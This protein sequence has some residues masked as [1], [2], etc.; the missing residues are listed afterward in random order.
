MMNGGGSP[1]KSVIERG[2]C[3]IAELGKVE[4]EAVANMGIEV[5]AL[6]FS[7]QEFVINLGRDAKV[8]VDGAAMGMPVPRTADW[9]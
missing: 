2:L 3:R 5:P 6:G 7:S 9:S 1:R 4:V 8:A